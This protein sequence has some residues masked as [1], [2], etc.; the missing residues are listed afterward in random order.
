MWNLLSWADLRSL[1]QRVQETPLLVNVMKSAPFMS[2][3]AKEES[4]QTSSE[5]IQGLNR[6][7]LFPLLNC[8]P[9]LHSSYLA[10]VRC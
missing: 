9:A 8:Y 4:T 6:W 1:T 7:I 2:Q 10:F 5:R 3:L